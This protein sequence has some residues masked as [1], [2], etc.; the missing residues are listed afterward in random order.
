MIN[1]YICV[2]T[3]TVYIQGQP[4]QKTLSNL[5]N[6]HCN[7]SPAH[8]IWGCGSSKMN[9]NKI[10]RNYWSGSCLTC[11]T[12]FAGPDIYTCICSYIITAIEKQKNVFFLFFKDV[13]R[14]RPQH[15]ARLT[16]DRDAEQQR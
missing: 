11:P 7:D 1:F 6:I 4:K 8:I 9:N 14:T 5:I 16:M 3:Y 15:G 2:Y 12:S 10:R 13:D